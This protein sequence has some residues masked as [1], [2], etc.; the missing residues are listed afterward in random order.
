[1]GSD[2]KDPPFSLFLDWYH[3]AKNKTIGRR[4]VTWLYPPAV[5]HQPDAMVLCTVRQD[6]QPSARV[7]LFKGLVD[8]EFTFYT[9]YSS[10]KSR[11]LAVNQRVALVFHWAFPE[12]QVRIEGVAKKM[13]R[14]ASVAY[15]N[16]RPRGSQLSGAASQQSAVITTRDSLLEKVALL[17]HQVGRGAIPCPEEWGGFAV[18]AERIEFWEVRINRLHERIRFTSNGAS[19]T[20]EML[21]P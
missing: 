2:H 7:V 1:M 9:N 18:A 20:R 4:I 8:G 16:S 5:I 11:E 17:K 19:W 10:Q 21:A 6:G 12:R 15:W 3:Q 14:E 13:S